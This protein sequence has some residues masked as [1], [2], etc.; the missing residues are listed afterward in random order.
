EKPAANARDVM[1]VVGISN[2]GLASSG[3]YRNYFENGGQRYSHLIDPGT[4][5]PVTHH[6]ASA[7][8]LSESAMLADAWATAFLIMGKEEGMKLADDQ[9][10]AVMFIDRVPGSSSLKFATAASEQFKSLTS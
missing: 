6:T 2:L 5:R 10:I 8:V 1:Q 4:G 9:G 7:T 3:D